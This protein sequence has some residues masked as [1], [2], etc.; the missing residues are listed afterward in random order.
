[1]NGTSFDAKKLGYLVKEIR[2]IQ[3]NGSRQMMQ[4]I[5]EPIQ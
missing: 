2:S 4:V 1:M 3:K 5:I